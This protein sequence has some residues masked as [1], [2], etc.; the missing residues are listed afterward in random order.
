MG[1]LISFM[2]FQGISVIFVKFRIVFSKPAE[3]TTKKWSEIYTEQQHSNHRRP[4]PAVPG[5]ISPP[6]SFWK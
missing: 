1:N 4:D 6:S 3:N 2:T 5:K